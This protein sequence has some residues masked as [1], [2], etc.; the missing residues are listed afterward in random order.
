MRQLGPILL[1]ISSRLKP[2]LKRGETPPTPSLSLGKSPVEV[3]S[4]PTLGDLGI[5]LGPAWLCLAVLGH[6]WP[7]LAVLGWS[8]AP[9]LVHKTPSPGFLAAWPGFPV[10]CVPCRCPE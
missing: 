9:S 4:H 7:C 1:F 2:P 10:V 5:P 3:N 8:L 6:P